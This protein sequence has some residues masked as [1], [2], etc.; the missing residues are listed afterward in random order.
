MAKN[1]IGEGIG[2][3]V[4]EGGMCY[5]SFQETQ[6]YRHMQEVTEAYKAYGSYWA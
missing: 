4:P 2:V 5:L 3:L 1:P 6:I